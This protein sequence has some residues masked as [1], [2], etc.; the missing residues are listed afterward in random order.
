MARKP[1][2]G[3]IGQ[4]WIGKHYADD[5]ENRGYEVVRY[6]LEETYVSRK[7]EIKTCEIVFIA[8]PAST[9]AEGFDDTN[10][11]D[12][13]GL[14]GAG[15]NAV[16]KSTL[17]PGET[18]V[19]QKDF[20]DIM[21]MHSPEFLSRNTAAYDAAHPHQ[22]IIGIPVDSAKYRACAQQVIDVLPEAPSMIVPAQ[23][24]EFFKYVHNTT[25]FVRS[26][27]M[28]LLYEVAEKL[29]ID[30]DD[31][32]K[33]IEH[34]PLLATRDPDVRH[35]HIEPRGKGGRGV[36]GDCMPKDFEIFSRLFAD[37]VG[38]ESGMR[39]IE[40]QKRKNISLLVSSEKD[41]ELL[42]GIYGDNLEIV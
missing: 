38:D 9:R 24:A 14:V 33:A 35:W 19:L 36:G 12:V 23:T 16:I 3:F 30:W 1:V 18:V 42:R 11:R 26:I 22:N 6:A 25:L 31:I 21:V 20:P 40:A 8:V 7:D 34:A 2:I 17:P 4:G 15:K 5:F 39:I 28:N 41:L 29:G 10:I 27:H 37:L 32:K 13:L